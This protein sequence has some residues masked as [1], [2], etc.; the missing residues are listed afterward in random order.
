MES[1][2]VEG[3]GVIRSY[4]SD[5]RGRDHVVGEESEDAVLSAV[6]AQI[7]SLIPQS[8][9]PHSALFYSPPNEPSRMSAEMPC[10]FL[11]T[12]ELARSQ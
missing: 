2:L 9:E 8:K 4:T 5:R 7:L 10:S 3:S 1:S 6:A 11:N 12:C